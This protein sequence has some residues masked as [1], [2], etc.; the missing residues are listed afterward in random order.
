VGIAAHVVQ[1]WLRSGEGLL[2]VDHLCEV[3]FSSELLFLIL[4]RVP[5]CGLAG[6]TDSRC[7]RSTGKPFFAAPQAFV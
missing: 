7:P 1:D 4:W 5:V 2:G 6:R 3:N